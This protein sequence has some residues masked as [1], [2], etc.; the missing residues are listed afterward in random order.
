MCAACRSR[1][2]VCELIR[3]VA[4]DGGLKVDLARTIQGRG[5]HFCPTP[6][7]LA[8]GI[9]RRVIGRALR[10]PLAVDMSSIH[11]QV[12][13]ALGDAIDAEAFR[14]VRDGFAEPCDDVKNVSPAL[15][16][17]P[18][19][20]GPG[21]IA[22]ESLRSRLRIGCEAHAGRL[23]W[24]ARAHALFTLQDLGAM[25]RRRCADADSGGSFTLEV[26]NVGCE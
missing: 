19:R 15:A 2:P 3:L 21:D 14:L 1:K 10:T 22:S 16:P 6:T 18:G 13:E 17:L 12:G 11:A 23:T 8:L 25:N 5:V 4:V 24:L 9:K 7:C 20:S 26:M